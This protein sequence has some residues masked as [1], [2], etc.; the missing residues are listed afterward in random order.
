MRIIILICISF[1]F[2]SCNDVKSDEDIFVDRLVY[3]RVDSSLFTG[4]LKSSD[5]GSTL[6]LHFKQGIPKGDWIESEP[7]GSVV[8]KG[9]YSNNIFDLST[10]KRELNSNFFL[11]NY[12]QEG[13]LYNKNTIKFLTVSIVVKDS[14]FYLH[15]EVYMKYF[16]TNL[17]EKSKI[18]LL[19]TKCKGINLE[20]V[21]GVYN[22]NK[23]YY[24]FFDVENKTINVD[25]YGNW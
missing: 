5:S 18:D 16:L 1:L 23:S 20:F 19:D 11:V 24:L 3:N 13:D 8:Q 9:I 22:W 25:K 21:N 17:F 6:L 15:D 4:V 12:W 10:L 14:F 7:S 2:S